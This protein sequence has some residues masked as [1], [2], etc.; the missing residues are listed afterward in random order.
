MV[1]AQDST[2]QAQ[3]E[4]G[5]FGEMIRASGDKAKSFSFLFSTKNYDWE[6]GLNYYGYRHYSPS[7]GRWLSRDPMEEDLES[8]L[9]AFSLN[10]PVSQF[11]AD[12]RI[13]VTRLPNTWLEG[14]CGNYDVEWI[15]QLDG[16]PTCEGYLV[17]KITY[18]ESTKKCESNKVKIIKDVFW[19]TSPVPGTWWTDGSHQPS[20]PGTQGGMFA[21]GEVKFF[22]KKKTG[23]LKKKWKTVP[24]GGLE[25]SKK[26]KWWDDPSDGGEATGVRL[27]SSDWNCCCPN[28]WSHSSAMP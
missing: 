20:R 21:Q 10:D 15:F 13:T 26:P 1:N 25:T 3:Y 8:N 27:A 22:C 12:G 24:G 6:T 7:V 4:Y 19:E 9:Y 16:K 17:Q 5:P 23:D 14:P 2:L 11:D 28:N 18:Y